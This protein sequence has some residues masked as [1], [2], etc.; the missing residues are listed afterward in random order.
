MENSTKIIPRPLRDVEIDFEIDNEKCM[1]CPDKPCLNSCPIEAIYLDSA[2]NLVKLNENC[3][4]CVLCTNSCPYDA[5]H[6]T[7]KLA[8]PI[9]ENVPNIN[10]KLCRACGACVGACKSGAI[11]L[12]STGSEEIH[13][14]IDEDKCIR[15]GYCFRSCPTDAIKYGEIL[16]KTIREGKTVLINQDLCIGCM[17]CT[18]VCPSKG[19]IE[20]GKT[21]KLPFIDPSYCARCG[22]CMNSCP[23]SAIDYAEREEA[24]ESFNSIKTLEI[25]SEILDNDVIRLSEGITK[26]D[27]VLID[28][29]D[30]L[31]GKYSFED[32]DFTDTIDISNVPK[33]TEFGALEIF[34]CKNCE[35][36]VVDVTNLLTKKL[37]AYIDSDLEILN[38]LDIVDFF[39]PIR[40]I[41]VIEDN[42]IGCGLCIDVCPSDAIDLEM[43]APIHINTN[44]SNIDL[45][46]NTG[47][48]V[49]CGKC[50]EV[51]NFDAI[52][53]EEEFFT[54]RNHEIFYIKRNL[55]GL[56]KG[57]VTIK[58]QFCQ[59]CGVCV[60]NCPVNALNIENNKIKVNQDKCISCRE[61]E[62]LCPVNAIKL[63]TIWQFL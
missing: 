21:N 9:R 28:L 48:C 51:C 58:H 10:K 54:N 56:K 55:K 23:T 25:A 62:C 52:H 40:S 36:I 27:N 26:I 14:E 32:F 42:C 33:D 18:R 30:E 59:L 8:D 47:N 4:G 11:H 46:N 12:V 49:Y 63:A 37:S 13:S 6:I 16:P 20:V 39:P 7:K 60:N 31:S 53:L 35:S 50:V 38:V 41:E 19:A 34:R 15:C 29:I 57:E 5:I 17:T 22:E 1:N 43:P 2:D 45:F 24:Y 3:F 44:N 61:C